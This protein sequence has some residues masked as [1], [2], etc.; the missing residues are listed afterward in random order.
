VI[1]QSHSPGYF[2]RTFILVPPYL[3]R[4]NFF[5]STMGILSLC[6]DSGRPPGMTMPLEHT[7]GSCITI[8]CESSEKQQSDTASNHNRVSNSHVTAYYSTQA[9]YPSS[10]LLHIPIQSSLHVISDLT[11]TT[12]PLAQQQPQP[13]L[14]QCN[15]FN[16]Q[17]WLS[18]SPMTNSNNGTPPTYVNMN[19]QAQSPKSTSPA[20]LLLPFNLLLCFILMATFVT[21]WLMMQHNRRT[22]RRQ[23]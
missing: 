16:T 20:L 17:E 10:T 2:L 14:P 12:F 6:A 11:C 7:Y 21:S 15:Y 5:R 18:A 1:V 3:S 19:E 4:C 9:A 22:T 8:E 13:P 23:R